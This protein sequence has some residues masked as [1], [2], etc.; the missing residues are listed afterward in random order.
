MSKIP[1]LMGANEI[2]PESTYRSGM[3]WLPKGKVNDQAI[4]KSC[5]ILVED[6]R[7]NTE[8]EISMYSE[9]D[10]HILVPREMF[11]FE[12]LPRPVV[13]CLVEG[14]PHM[15]KD[16]ITLR[17]NQLDAWKALYFSRGGILN[18]G[19]GH[20]KTVLA[21]KKVLATGKATIVVIPNTGLMS[22]WEDEA[23]H[24]LLLRPAEIGII[25]QSK[26]EWDRPFVI[27][28]LQTLA[29]R[30]R[31]GAIPPEMQQHFGLAIWDEVHHLSA[32]LFSLTAP[33]FRGQR[34]GLSAT[35][36]RS[37]GLEAIYMAHLG[38]IFHSDISHEI[39]PRIYFHKLPTQL[40]MFDSRILDR[41]GNFNIGKFWRTLGEDVG[42]NKLILQQIKLAMD[43]GRKVLA[44]SHSKAHVQMLHKIVPHAGL[45]DGDV[46][47]KERQQILK[48]YPVVFATTQV[49]QEGLDAPMLD[50]L[51]F[52]TPF[53]EWNIVQQGVGRTLRTHDDKRHPVAVFFWDYDVPA[54]H[55]MCKAIMKEMRNRDWN[56]KVA[57]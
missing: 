1:E 53:K 17:P 8:H 51:F 37:D 56:F 25:Q 33:L 10:T 42:R 15:F 30:A 11:P 45:I 39:T 19:C 14:T 52:L 12:E 27:A 47:Q 28:S 38:K 9:T 40:N 41:A 20:G 2:D 22:Q 44:L 36:R 54:G 43:K 18:L 35:P 6:T 57:G 34:L 5:T 4:R 32:P 13:D 50:T 48:Q 46:P 23:R 24:K 31:D 7:A 3:L 26:F 55:A 16:N 21:L 29:R 49:A